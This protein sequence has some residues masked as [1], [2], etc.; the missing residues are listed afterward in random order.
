MKQG[1]LFQRLNHSIRF[2][3]ILMA[4]FALIG[5]HPLLNPV[6]PKSQAYGGRRTEPDAQP[7]PSLPEIT[8]WEIYA[9]HG[10]ASVRIPLTIPES[11]LFTEPRN[12]SATTN[13]FEIEMTFAEPITEKDAEGGLFLVGVA[14]DTSALVRQYG[15][16]EVELVDGGQRLRF[17]LDLSLITTPAIPA[18]YQFKLTMRLIDPN[19]VISDER[20]VYFLTGDVNGDGVVDS[21]DETGPVSVNSVLGQLPDPRR[22]TSVRADVD[23]S[24]LVDDAATAPDT[25]DLDEVGAALALG[26]AVANILDLIM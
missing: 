18:P 11:G 25:D 15:S 23:V 9:E 7:E 8:K 5:C 21:L 4:G 24:G 16:P 22:P 26:N 19:Q 10:A 2:T 20:T 13:V 3:A 17:L 14:N 1:T 6:D 12:V